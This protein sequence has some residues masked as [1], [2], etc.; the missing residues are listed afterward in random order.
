[1]F[2]V[3]CK[4]DDSVDLEVIIDP[5]LFQ[6]T[7]PKDAFSTMIAA[8][9]LKRKIPTLKFAF[10]DVE[11]SQTAYETVENK[12]YFMKTYATASRENP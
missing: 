5:E 11:E 10:C 3:S 6:K 1:M 7:S 2:F 12:E 8:S 4:N 9:T